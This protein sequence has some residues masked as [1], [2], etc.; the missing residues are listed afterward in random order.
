MENLLPGEGFTVPVICELS[1]AHQTPTW[2]AGLLK[3]RMRALLMP[4]SMDM[5]YA[6]TQARNQSI[7]HPDSLFCFIFLFTAIIS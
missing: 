7:I 2:M 6:W 4:Y 1:Q 3:Q 5:P